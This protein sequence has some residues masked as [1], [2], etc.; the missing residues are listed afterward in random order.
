MFPDSNFIFDILR[1]LK[2][3]KFIGAIKN[4][5]KLRVSQKSLIVFLG[6]SYSTIDRTTVW[7]E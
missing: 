4:P 1:S 3:L 2:N 5:P 7:S 6:R